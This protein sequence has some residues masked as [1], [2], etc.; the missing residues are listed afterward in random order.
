MATARKVLVNLV[1]LLLWGGMAWAAGSTPPPAAVGPQT[2]AGFGGSAG[3]HEFLLQAGSSWKGDLTGIGAG[4]TWSLVILDIDATG[5]TGPADRF[6]YFNLQDADSGSHFKNIGIN[7]YLDATGCAGGTC[8]QAYQQWTSEGISSHGLNVGVLTTSDFDLR[9]DFTKAA[10]GNGWFITPYF[11][12]AAGSWTAFSGGSFTAS[13]GSIDFDAG[14]LIVGFD[15]GADGSLSFS[16]YYLEGPPST[17][18]VDDDWTASSLGDAV[19]FPGQTDYQTFGVDAFDTVQDG[20][21]AVVASTV[22]VA[23]GTYPDPVTIDKSLSIIGADPNAPDTTILSG[24]VVIEDSF[25]G[26]LLEALTLKGDGPGPKNAVIDSR[27]TIGAVSDIT[28]RNCILD[29]EDVAGRGAFYGHFITGTWTFDRNEIMNFPSWYVIDNTGSSFDAPM[30]LSHVVFTDNDIHD[31]GG[32]IAFRGKIGEEIETAV[33][34]GNTIDYS[35]IASVDSETWAAIELN[36]VLDL[37]VF[38]NFVHDVPEASWGGEGQAFQFWS[39]TPWTVDIHDNTITDNFQGIYFAGDIGDPNLP[40]YVPTGSIN[41]NN[42][43]GNQEF[44]VSISDPPAGTG[45]SSSIGGP[46]DAEKNWWGDATGAD[47]PNNN[48]HPA[49]GGDAVSENVDSI[50]W[51]A[52]STTTPSSENVTVTHNPVIALSD[53]IQGAIDAA[54]S[55]DT[56]NI[57]AGT[58][59]EGPQIVVDKDITVIGAGKTL[60]VVKPTGDTASSGDARGWWLVETGNVLNLSDLTLDGTG[61]KIWQAIRHKGEGAIDNVLFTEIKFNESGPHYSGVAIAAFGTGPVDVTNSM[62]TEIGRVGVLYFGTGINGSVFDSNIYTGKGD[63]DFLDYMID[64]GAGAECTI[65]GNIVTDNRGVASSDG[66]TSA[67]IMVTTFWG[68]GTA[69]TIE[70]NV[71]EDNTAGIAVGYKTEDCPGPAAACD[72]AAATVTCNRISGNEV[73]VSVTVE[74]GSTV[75]INDNSIAGNTEGIDADDPNGVTGVFSGTV[76]AKFNWWGSATGPG[77]AGPGTGDP[78]TVNVDFS[79]FESSVPA[80]VECST[81]AHCSDFLTCTGTEICNSGACEAGTP[82]VCSDQCESGVCEEPAGT[83]E[84]A[85]ASTPCDSGEDTCSEADT[86]DGNKNCEN[87]GGGGDTDADGTCQLDDNCP[88]DPNPSQDDQ[89]N[90]GEGD[91]CDENDA[92][93]LSIKQVKVK[94]SKIPDRDS[95]Y[96]V[97]ELDATT[98][99]ALLADAAADG[100]TVTVSK[101][102]GGGSLVTVNSFTF[103]GDE[104]TDKRGSLRCKDDDTKSRLKL[105]KRGA[106]EFFRIKMKVKRQVLTLPDLADTPLVITVQT[107]GF[108][109]RQDEIDDCTAKPRKVDCREAP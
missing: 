9:F 109:D 108:I 53:T 3:A 88:D 52:T 51:L 79:M 23:A 83:C 25:S 94:K 76:D 91:I 27:P 47:D 33:I 17:T 1:V 106:V 65:S 6:I 24:G 85:A 34:S 89:D 71:I 97:G 69:A 8:M 70:G 93:G 86:C 15:G 67:G 81:N 41:Y 37:E 4:P 5:V 29:G 82:I 102:G 62:F 14:K 103:T 42:I 104:C 46:L 28:I 58:F 68:A 77:G 21:D 100:A 48:P 60:T 57:V 107:T 36:K 105:Q 90:D 64:A 73:G 30:K 39:L 10:T 95:W 13:V 2:L 43:S 99:A 7:F 101:Q 49:P 66:S 31:V 19:Q 38:D 12:L 40:T 92:A 18:Y 63:G 55:G 44:G 78:V 74:D 75:V 35:A 96:A 84:P 98:S 32:S 80:C 56:L 11:R 61:F 16:N 72:T 50:P 87:T 20:I 45:S 26:L 54:L 59:L 22:N